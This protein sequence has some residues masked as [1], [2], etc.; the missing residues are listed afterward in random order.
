MA[1][2]QNR[3]TETQCLLSGS[4]LKLAFQQAGSQR[5]VGDVYTGVCRPIVPLKLQ[6][7]IFFCICTTFHTLGGLPLGVLCLLGLSGVA[8]PMT[9]PAGQNSASTA[10]RARS[11]ATPACCR[12]PSPSL[13]GSLLISTLTWWVLYSTVQCACA[14]VFSWI[15]RFGVPE[16]ITSDHGPQFTSNVWS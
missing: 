7:D 2:E 14:L 13:N 5:Q 1:T 10:S 15:T 3:Y 6:K 9:S 8:S 16:M 4:S 11:I 12:N